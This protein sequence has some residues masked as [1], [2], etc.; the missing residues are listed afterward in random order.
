LKPRATRG[1][2]PSSEQAQRSRNRRRPK[3]AQEFGDDH[4]LDAMGLP[5]RKTRWRYRRLGRFPE[6]VS[7]CGRKLYDLAEIRRYLANPEAWERARKALKP[8]HPRE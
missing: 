1:H 6:P 2:Q 7:V 4:D 3:P 5:S 8:T